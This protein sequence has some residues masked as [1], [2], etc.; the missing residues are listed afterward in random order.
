M[1]SEEKS[2]LELAGE[3]MR[4]CWVGK[5][6]ISLNRN[7][8]LMDSNCTMCGRKMTVKKWEHRPHYCFKCDQDIEGVFQDF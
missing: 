5:H 2:V 1:D 3:H 4:K 7:L 8:Q 6:K